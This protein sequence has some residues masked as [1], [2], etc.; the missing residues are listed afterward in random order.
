M[1]NMT[2]NNNN[3]TKNPGNTESKILTSARQLF[4]RRDYEGLSMRHL[5][6]ESGV[7]LS[8]IYHFFEDKDYL[9]KAVYLQTNRQLGE[10][11]KALQQKPTAEQMLEQ[12]LDFQFEHIEEVVFVIKY[13][14][15]YRDDFAALPTKT[16]P[17]KAAL[18]IEEILQKGNETGEFTI[19]PK[20]IPM[21]AKIVA[22]TING[23][24]LEYYPA[25]P[26]GKDRQTV[27]REITDF[28]MRALA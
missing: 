27:I 26:K 28:A 9:L 21:R 15:H 18:H 10:A 23:F 16:L 3:A 14:M 6:A 20:D 25:V 7:S 1:K 4:A 11:R 24:L 17:P 5:S 13:Y 8:S 19:E 12:I 2:A 22:H